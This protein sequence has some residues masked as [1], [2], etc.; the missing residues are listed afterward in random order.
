[1]RGIRSL[2][3][4][5][6]VLTLGCGGKAAPPAAAPAA[7]AEVP[8]EPAAPPL[9]VEDDALPEIPTTPQA[10]PA[11]LLAAASIGEP[12]AW[13]GDLATYADAVRPGI[14]MM[15]TPSTILGQLAGFGADLSGIDLARPVRVLVLDPTLYHLPLVAVVGVANEAALR[16]AADQN[17]LT[18]IVHGGWAAIGDRGALRTAA[19]YALTTAVA[20]AAPRPLTAT[21][22]MATVVTRFRPMLDAWIDAMLANAGPK[23]DPNTRDMMHQY[24]DVLGQLERIEISVTADRDRATFTTTLAPRTDGS[25][26]RFVAQQR[27]AVFTLVERLGAAA[28]IFG[29]RIDHTLLFAAMFDP[30]LKQTTATYGANVATVATTL[31]SQWVTVMNG[32]HAM[33]VSKPVTGMQV[34]GLW[35]TAAGPKVEALVLDYI[36]AIAGNYA[37]KVKPRRAT[38]RGVRHTNVGIVIPAL[39]AQL[40]SSSDPDLGDL[41]L[42][43]PGKTFAL[44]FGT[45]APTTMRALIDAVVPPKGRK[46]AAV[47]PGLAA[48]LTA[49]RARGDSYVVAVDVPGVRVMGDPSAPAAPVSR[50]HTALTFGFGGGAIVMRM[51]VPP[52]QIAPLLP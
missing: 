7:R 19:P 13:I 22:A 44:A 47:A 1:M 16:A 46:P 41:Y 20:T 48:V 40:G 9:V 24:L 12:V 11:E 15:V 37:A 42:A 51:T 31:F 43:A 35:D 21:I 50:E 25:V 4:A 39:A 29:G 18:V 28:V 33:A 17:H 34:T 52:S 10:A 5:V 30:W 45:D 14:G 3:V 26:A 23:V 36:D 2:V 8:V 38:Y 6:L 49:A 27:P 32:E